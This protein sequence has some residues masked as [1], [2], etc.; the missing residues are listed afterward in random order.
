MRVLEAAVVVLP[1]EE[2]EAQPVESPVVVRFAV[3]HLLLLLK[4]RLRIPQTVESQSWVP[5]R[6][7][8]VT[9]QLKMR[10]NLWQSALNLQRG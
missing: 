4:P 2:Y 10:S 1:Y 5:L 9:R 7:A 6:N 3:G 8:L